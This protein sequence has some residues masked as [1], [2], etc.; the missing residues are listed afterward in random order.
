MS[1]R[2]MRRKAALF[3][4]LEKTLDSHCYV[5]FSAG[6]DSSV[7]AHACQSIR[8]D[9][10]VL[11]ADPGVPWHWL[12]KERSMWAD[13]AKAS[14]WNLRLFP[15]DKWA[16]VDGER[17]TDKAASKIHGGMF[18]GLKSYADENGLTTSIQGIRADESRQRSLA[19]WCFGNDHTRKDG[20]RVIWP[21]MRWST[22]DVWAYII[23]A[24]L[25]WLEIYS[26]AGP[27]ARNGLVGVHGAA[28]GRLAYLKRYFPQAYEAARS[29]LP[30]EIMTMGG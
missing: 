7:I 22:D 2:F 12:E 26:V 21:I 18:L 20:V 14:G 19:A 24:G 23:E 16:M 1:T 28:Y 25:P 3:S 6:K 9:I 10:P 29:V 17:D 13:Y 8:S 15:F 27:S 30:T 4:L 5:S 11:M